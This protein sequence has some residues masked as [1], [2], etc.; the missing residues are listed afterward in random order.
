MIPAL[1]TACTEATTGPGDPSGVPTWSEDVRRIVT[2]NCVEC[3]REGGIAPFALTSYADAA[4]HAGAIAEATGSRRMPPSNLDNSGDCNTFTNARWLT[5]D[6]IATLRAWSDGGAPEGQPGKEAASPPALPALDRVDRTVEMTE[7]YTPD[8]T[9]DDDYRCFVLD[10]GLTEDAYVTGFRVRLGAPE[11]VHHVTLFALDTPEAERQAEALDAAAPGPGYACFG[12]T[13]AP[14]RWVAGSG[15]GNARAE[16]PPGTGTVMRA[17]RKT[18]L[19]VHY[20]RRNGTFTDQ[21]AIDLRLAPRVEHPTEVKRV[22]APD[23]VLPP[24]MRE[25]VATDT[26]ELGA[27]VTLWGVWPHMHDLGRKMLITAVHRGAERCLAKVDAYEFHW[28]AFGFY[29]TPIRLEAGDTL[30]ITCT[31]DTSDRDRTTVWGTGTDDE[32][33]IGFF[34]AERMGAEP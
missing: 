31:Y 3:H 2:Q 11:I 15:P 1:L 7:P 28:Q 13:I 32:M 10:P 25:V 6:D 16:L 30:R 12:D 22:A 18:V 17:G 34:Y 29:E 21:T 8:A 14:T 27:D 9:L 4:A 19:Q 20:N 26:V 23:L 24:R 33:C 5:D